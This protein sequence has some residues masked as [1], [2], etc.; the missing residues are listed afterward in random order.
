MTDFIIATERLVLRRWLQSDIKPFA[1]MNKD[2]DVMK[3]FPK[4]LTDKE[5]SEMVQRIN[6]Q[7]DE[8]N[9][10]LYAVESKLT[11]QFIGFTGFAIPTF[12]SFFTPCIEIGRR[13]KKETWRQGFATEAASA[14]L[15]YGFKTL[16]FE[17]V[18]SFTSAININSEKVMIK[19]GMTIAGEFNH[20][21]IEI[22][23]PLCKHVLYEIY[24]T[25]K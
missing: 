23:S 15:Q 10:S 4:T 9:F 24:N 3:Y 18:V 16:H 7:F 19:I 17:K 20:P 5:T 6:L 22:S 13:Y 14:C 11:R 1:E 8:N 12:E 2:A 21:R 25:G